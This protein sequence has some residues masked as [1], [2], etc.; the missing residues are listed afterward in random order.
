MSLYIA[1]LPEMFPYLIETGPDEVHEITAVLISSRSGVPN[2]SSYAVTSD[3]SRGRRRLWLSKAS[4]DSLVSL[5][6]VPAVFT[7]T[8]T[9]TVSEE[10]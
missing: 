7:A 8:E 10:T 6:I 4:Y 5:R 3:A 9:K 2:G 1:R